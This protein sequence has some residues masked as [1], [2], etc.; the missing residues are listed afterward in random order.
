MR[1]RDSGRG[2]SPPLRSSGRL[3]LQLLHVAA[4]RGGVERGQRLC[5]VQLT[6]GFL[7]IFDQASAPRTDRGVRC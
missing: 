6:L 2:G 1:K 4:F 3:S 7:G 5:G